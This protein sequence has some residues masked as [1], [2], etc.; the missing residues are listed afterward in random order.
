MN[1][2]LFEEYLEGLKEAI[3]ADLQEVLFK[4]KTFQEKYLEYIE[5]K[6]KSVE[7]QLSAQQGPS[8]MVSQTEYMNLLINYSVYRKLFGIEDSK[9]YSKI[10]SLQKLCPILVVYNNLYVVPG[11]FLA[12]LCPLKKKTKVDPENI[13]LFIRAELEQREK[14]F[15]GIVQSY[16]NRLVLWI[17]QMNSD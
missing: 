11:N 13:S 2:K 7:A 4:N 14:I 15:P 16:Y 17:T 3:R 10:W 6:I 5:S 8:I 12:E 9:I 1:G